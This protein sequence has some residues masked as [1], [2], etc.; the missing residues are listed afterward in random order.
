MKRKFIFVMCPPFQGSTVIVNLLNSSSNVSTFLDCKKTS[1]GEGQWLYKYHGDVNYE[2]NRWNPKY[3]LDMNMVNKVFNTYLDKNKQ[4]WV[5]KSPPNICRAKQFQ[6]YFSKLGEVY[7]IISIRNPYSASNNAEE[8]VKYANFQKKNIETLKNRIYVTYEECCKNLD[9][10]ILKFTNRIPGLGTIYNNSIT[11]IDNERCTKIHTNKVDRI[12]DKEKKNK[13]LKK[14]LHIVKYFNY[15]II[16]N[17]TKINMDS[18]I[19]EYHNMKGLS[20]DFQEF[21]RNKNNV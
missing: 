5:E 21:V 10:V 3:K 4:I 14:N 7:F 11:S 17:N 18:L 8:W 9:K 20:D 2:N 16:D 12:L 19:T 13:I 1:R 15:T 6:D